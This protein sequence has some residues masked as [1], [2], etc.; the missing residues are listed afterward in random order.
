M[1]FSVKVNNGPMNKRLNSGGDLD[2]RLD[3]GL[4]SGFVTI[5]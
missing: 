3:M 1:K 4:Y 5:G 2:N